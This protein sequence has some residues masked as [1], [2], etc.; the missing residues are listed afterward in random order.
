[1]KKASKCTVAIFGCTKGEEVCFLMSFG[2]KN[3][4]QQKGFM[5]PS[6]SHVLALLEEV[7]H[8]FGRG[9]SNKSRNHKHSHTFTRFALNAFTSAATPTSNRHN[10]LVVDPNSMILDSLESLGCLVSRECGFIA[11]G[12]AVQKLWAK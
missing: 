5:L 9:I 6:F 12:S 11:F 7:G 1:M 10:S 8:V 4:Y 2:V 3:V